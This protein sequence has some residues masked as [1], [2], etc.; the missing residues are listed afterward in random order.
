MNT[1]ELTACELP[2]VKPRASTGERLCVWFQNLRVLHIRI[3]YRIL[4]RAM[5]KDKI[6]R[7]SW[8][9]NIAMPI[10][11]SLTH[12]DHQLKAGAS[13]QIADRLMKHLFNA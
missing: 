7:D 6:F 1:N 5:Q 12:W 9:A 13:N 3:A 8:Q 11:D 4:S 10:Y 2:D